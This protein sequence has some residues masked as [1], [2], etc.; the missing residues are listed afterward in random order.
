MYLLREFKEDGGH[1]ASFAPNSIKLLLWNR[2]SKC[3]GPAGYI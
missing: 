3:M 1:K 2:V